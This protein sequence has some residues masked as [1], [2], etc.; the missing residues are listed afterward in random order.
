MSTTSHSPESS[1]STEINWVLVALV[2]VFWLLGSMIVATQGVEWFMADS[3]SAEAEAVDGLFQ[4]ML[5]IA[6]FVFLLVETLIVYIVVRYGFMR[7]HD[8]DAD[9]PPIHG[10]NTI[11]IVWTL[12]PAVVV[13]IITIYSFVVLLDTTEADVPEEDIEDITVFGQQFFWSFQY[14]DDDFE[15]TANNILVV[16]EGKTVRLSM[17]TRDV[18]HAF[19][20]PEFRVKQDLMPNRS[21]ELLFTPTE[22]TGLPDDIELVTLEDL[23]IPT[24]ETA[25]PDETLAE[26]VEEEEPEQEEVIVLMGDEI[27]QGVV[28]PVDYEIGYPIVC[29]ELCGANHGV[30]HG[31]VFVVEEAIFEAYV[32]S[33]RVRAIKSQADQEFAIRCGGEAINTAGRALFETYGCNTCHM[34]PDAGANNMGAGPSLVG[35]GATALPSGYENH[36]DYIRRSIIA[37]N[38][39]IAS[40]YAAGIMP[41]NFVDRIAPEELDIL[42]AYLAMQTE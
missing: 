26:T 6:T 7:K 8:D 4:F 27:E 35:I 12:I 42:V 3:A 16:P 32:E 11:E 10:N 21:T 20:V 14:P 24:A 31:R 29:A 33:L 18:M 38:E 9:G 15:L 5:F 41:Q 25:C 30:M 1:S 2:V 19:W 28:P 37:P 36:E 13:F 22:I 34:L 39:F 17:T 23:D 40:G